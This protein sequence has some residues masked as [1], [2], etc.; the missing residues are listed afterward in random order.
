MTEQQTHYIFGPKA[1][2]A[3]LGMWFSVFPKFGVLMILGRSE[4]HMSSMVLLQKEPGDQ[5]DVV[6][7]DSFPLEE[8]SNWLSTLR[9]TNAEKNRMG[10]QITEIMLSDCNS[11]DDLQSKLDA[12]GITNMRFFTMQ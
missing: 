4:V 8:E 1:F 6:A 11:Q 5:W 7:M 3:V 12:A 2:G 9:I 10:H